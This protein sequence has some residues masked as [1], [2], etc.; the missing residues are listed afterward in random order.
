MADL[1]MIIR[2]WL[3]NN[4]WT[5]AMLADVLG[6]SES[7]VQ[8]WVVGKN[9]PSPDMLEKLSKVMLID[10]QDFYETDYLPFEYERLDDFIPPCLY[11]E[12]FIELMRKMGQPI[13]EKLIKEP[14]P[15]QD[16]RHAVYDAGLYLG[17]KLHRF[18]N[19]A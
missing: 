10:I 9:H 5:Q 19:P 16:T 12:G 17:A 1:G 13:P 14:L 18:K 2:I 8:K 4:E 7:T 11:G 15:R 6:V 3:K